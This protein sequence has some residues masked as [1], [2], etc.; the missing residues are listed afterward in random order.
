MFLQNFR[1]DWSTNY[2]PLEINFVNPIDRF[3][4]TALFVYLLLL[5]QL[6]FILVRPLKAMHYADGLS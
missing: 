5:L 2:K 4:A 1:Y 6:A 3:Q